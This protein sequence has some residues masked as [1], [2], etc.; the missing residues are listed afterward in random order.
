MLVCAFAL[1]I[2]WTIGD[3][4]KKGLAYAA[5]EEMANPSDVEQQR[6]LRVDAGNSAMPQERYDFWRGEGS[7]IDPVKNSL[8]TL[9]I[10]WCQRYAKSDARARAAIRASIKTEDFSTLLTFSGRASVFAIREHN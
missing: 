6:R 7:L 8:D 5:G 2:P 3:P 10:A 4:G 9:L 1:T